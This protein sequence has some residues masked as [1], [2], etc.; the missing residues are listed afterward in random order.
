MSAD[1][2]SARRDWEDGAR[3]LE[4]VSRE[5]AGQAERLQAQLD[6]VAAELRRRVGGMFTVAA[7]AQAYA[8]AE[9]W[10]RHA[11]EEEAPTPGWARTVSLVVDAAFH[12]YSRGAIDYTP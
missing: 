2:E 8:G 11:I 5:D 6:V 1:L 7:L 4:R 10:A 12:A 3:R 9:E